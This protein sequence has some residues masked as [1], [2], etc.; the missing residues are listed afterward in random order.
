MGVSVYWSLSV[1]VILVCMSVKH[2][3]RS[4]GTK[5]PRLD[6]DP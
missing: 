6:M 4:P 1:L 5:V 3:S 2:I